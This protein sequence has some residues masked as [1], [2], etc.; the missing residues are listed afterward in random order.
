LTSLGPI[1]QR[2][3]E[4]TNSTTPNAIGG[5]RSRHPAIEQLTKLLGALLILLVVI[6]LA[7]GLWLRT[8]IKASVARYDGT[9]ALPGLKASTIIERDDLGVPTLKGDRIADVVRATGFIHAQE[10][11]FQMDLLRRQSAGELAALLG[12]SAAGGDRT[13]RI[14]RFRSRA[15]QALTMLPPARRELLDAYAAGVNAGLQDLGSVPPEYLLLRT[16]PVPWMPEDSFLVIYSMFLRLQDPTGRLDATLGTLFEVLPPALAAFLAPSG[17]RWDAPVAGGPFDLLQTPGPDVLDLRM[18]PAPVLS[19]EVFSTLDAPLP[20][21]NS[22]AV[23]GAHTADGAALLANDMHLGLGMPNVWFRISQSWTEDGLQREVLGVSL[24]GYPF[25]V[26]GSNRNIA[27]GYT[28]S[29]GDWTDLVVLDV[30]RADA[31]RYL[32]PDGARPFVEHAEVIEIKGA[33]SQTLTVQETIWGP[34]VDRDRAGRPRVAR[35]VAHLPEAVNLEILD[36]IDADTVE[37]AMEAAHRT[38]LPAQN[39][40]VVDKSGN[41]GWTI[42]GPVPRRRGT[43]GRLPASW[44]DGTTRWDG[45]V[46]S[47]AVPRLLNPGGGRL[48]TANAR[49]V[50]GEPLRIL[51]DG[52]YALGSRARQIRDSLMEIERASPQ[53]MLELQLDD[54]ALFLEPWHEL[55]MQV[56]SE[57]Q[58]ARGARIEELLRQTRDTWTGRASVDSVAYLMVREWRSQV[59]Q[60]VLL[61]LVASCAKAD[62]DFTY[63][64][65]GERIEG[66]LWQLVTERPVHLLDPRYGSWN[67]LFRDAAEDVLKQFVGDD[68]Q[69]SLHSFTWGARN[70]FAL[71]HPTSRAVPLIA[72]WLD[73]PVRA[74]PGDNHMPRVQGP[75]FGASVRFV[76][77]PGREDL[78]IF[79]MPGGE[80][81]HPLSP[82]YRAG[83]EFWANGHPAPFLAGASRRTLTLTPPN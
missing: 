23:S 25:V 1:F 83:H 51:G 65:V 60:K 39:L 59:A 3:A 32:T 29:Q 58:G 6:G 7:G 69:P 11:Y 70:T 20:G 5:V 72:R 36:L 68:P 61:P 82:Y 21:S 8:Q 34:V 9:V 79:Q 12:A 10:R 44:T 30:D 50:S 13:A 27:W 47:H 22:W 38:G 76:V 57:S 80:S 35:W 64:R 81:G 53:R 45:W 19:G 15:Q 24:P 66:P 37:E 40:L 71:R 31:S 49:V 73:I 41:I 63:L 56:L 74:Y 14:H 4:L 67:Q 43:D 17:S 62:S 54:R 28:N 52:G 55:M 18:R 78:G 42:L 48:W 33:P 2:L 16:R 46:P 77:S 26:A 75:G